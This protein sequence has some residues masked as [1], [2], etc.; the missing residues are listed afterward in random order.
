MFMSSIQGGDNAQLKQTLQDLG[1]EE[2]QFSELFD[3]LAQGFQSGPEEE[4]VSEI[5][6]NLLFYLSGQVLPDPAMQGQAI[7]AM[8]GQ[9]QGMIDNGEFENISSLT[10]LIESLKQGKSDSRAVL[11]RLQNVLAMGKEATAGEGASILDAKRLGEDSAFEAD[12]LLKSLKGSGQSADSLEGRVLQMG[13]A[14]VSGITSSVS[15]TDANPA[16]PLQS[17]MSS[18]VSSSAPQVS[19]NQPVSMTPGQPGWDMQVGQRLMFMV[20][21]EMQSAEIR[22][23][24]AELGPMEVKVR[25]DGD[26]VSVVFQVLN[27]PVRDAI[28]QGIPRLREFFAE[29]GMNL[30]DVDVSQQGFS[31]KEEHQEQIAGQSGRTPDREASVMTQEAKDKVTSTADGLIDYYI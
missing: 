13:Q 22:L 1:I 25:N 19:V 21:R 3:S 18:S 7:S 5:L 24:P 4:S 16:L 2:Q 11:D 10:Q 6:G 20:N 14:P 28:E 31:G 15:I 27:A 23:N 29:Q 17:L 9:L 26:R 8:L 12:Q 30:V